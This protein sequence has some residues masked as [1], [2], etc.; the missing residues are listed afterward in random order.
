[1]FSEQ[2]C[3]FYLIPKQEW[4]PSLRASAT[5]PRMAGILLNENK[6]SLGA[7]GTKMTANLAS[8]KSHRSA[9][10]G[11][12]K[13]LGSL[14]KCV[15]LNAVTRDKVGDREVVIKRRNFFGRKILPMANWFF[16]VTRA[17]VSYW[18]DPRDWQH[19]TTSTFQ[20]LNPDYHAWPVGEGAVHADILPGKSLWDHLKQRT[21][22]PRMMHAAGREIHRAHTFWSTY[23]NGAWSHGDCAMCNVLY[24]EE[25]DRARLI[26]FEIVHHKH[27]PAICR[28]AQDLMSVLLDLTG[29]PEKRW[30]ELAGAFIDAYGD[31]L[32]IAELRSRFVPPRGLEVLWWKV[33]VNFADTAKVMRQLNLL[34]ES[35]IPE[36]GPRKT[37]QS[38][39]HPQPYFAPNSVAIQTTATP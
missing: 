8:R 4:L 7:G 34:D 36:F 29:A 9:R 27:L 22:T 21:L 6:Q 2:I 23:H 11:L 12:D 19:W 10:Q 3:R 35:L 13:T 37:P 24:D 38:R 33:R 5:A 18:S 1:M 16:K 15:H 28:H 30:L 32:V 25:K 39:S 20:M 31:P 26:D 17:P 14:V